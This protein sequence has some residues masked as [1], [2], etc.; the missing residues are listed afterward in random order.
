MKLICFGDSLTEGVYGGSYVDALRRLHPQH[1]IVNDGV[2][3]S[4]VINLLRRVDT[5]I[6]DAPDAVFIM[7]GGNDAISYSFPGTRSYYRKVH[8]IPDGVVTPDQ[9][10]RAYRELL[11][12]LHLAHLL[13]YIGLPPTEYNPQTAAA[14]QQYNALAAEAARAVGAP[15]LD[16]LTIMMPPVIPDRPPLDIDTILTIGTRIKR[17]WKAYE[18]ARAAG[19]FTFTFDGLHL[20]PEGAET[21]A[22]HVSRFIGL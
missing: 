21:I 1:E 15:V 19:G 6:A 9:F 12:R 3:G 22:G 17:G 13:T 5:V 8:A 18:T 16:L 7:I 4:T 14:F 11:E 20:T 10:A 2:G